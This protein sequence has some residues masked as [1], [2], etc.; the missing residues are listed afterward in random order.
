MTLHLYSKGFIDHYTQWVAHGESIRIQSSVG[1]SSSNFYEEQR[2][3]ENPGPYRTMVMDAL[4]PQFNFNAGLSDESNIEIE[5]P[6]S[7]AVQFF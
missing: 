1:E 3:F 5:E 4:G 2:L 7:E 6:N